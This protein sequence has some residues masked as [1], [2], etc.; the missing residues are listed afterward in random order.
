MPSRSLTTTLGKLL[1]LEQVATRAWLE[2]QNLDRHTLDNLLKSR[3]LA[4][5]TK[6]VYARPQLPVTW[7]GVVASLPRLVSSPVVLGGL[8]AL[9]LQGYAQYLRIDPTPEIHLWSSTPCPGWL[10]RTF[11]S[12]T[13][14]FHWHTGKRLWME[15]WPRTPEIKEVLWLERHPLKVSA[16]EQAWLE[17]LATVPNEISLEHADQILQGLT[18]LSP[19]RLNQLLGECR[20]VQVK[21][22]FFYLADRQRHSWQN[23]VASRSFDLGSGKRMLV[24]GGKLDPRY[25][26]TVPAELDHEQ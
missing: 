26:I 18:T 25:L 8:S 5:L 11:G 6:G 4:L 24:P 15:G 14:N 10:K 1:P 17:L 22:I 9:E 20:S 13:A 21:R 19:R 3:Q 7:Q 2:A 12:L 16:P 23:H